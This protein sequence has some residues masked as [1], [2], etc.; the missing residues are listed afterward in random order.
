METIEKKK[1]HSWKFAFRSLHGLRRRMILSVLC[2]MVA[3]IINYLPPMV[4]RFTLDYVVGGKA[5]G[6]PVPFLR[7]LES[8]GGRNF[9]LGHIFLCG[10]AYFVCMAVSSA[11]FF[12]RRVFSTSAAEGM[13]KNMRDALYTQLHDVP[14]DYHKH[15]S[16]GDIVQR[17]IS[18][19]NTVRRFFSLQVMEM[20]RTVLMFFTAF[21]IMMTIDVPL[22][23]LSLVTL[24][25]L[26]AASY[27]YFRYVKKYFTA[28]DVAEGALST[29]I[30]ENLTGARVV[31]AFGQQRSQMD[32]FMERNHDYKQKTSKLLHMLGVYW[33]S[34]D[35]VGFVQIFLTLLFGV[36]FA[37]QGRLSVGDVTLF[38]AY[39]GMLTWP[40]RQFGRILADMGKSS[41]ALGRL[42][43]I[44]DAKREEE[45]GAALLPPMRGDIVF[46]DV[47][48]G[49]DSPDEVLK[50]LSFTVCAGQ[51]VG[52]LGSTGSGKSSL[53]QL[54][55]RLYQ[56]SGGQITV[57]GTD[58]REIAA[59]HLRRN[60]SLVAQ[61][62]FLYSRS[63]LENIR[64]ARPG[65]T[66]EEVFAAASAAAIHEDITEFKEGYSTVVGERGVTL[67]GGQRQRVAIARALLQNAPVMIFD[68]SM[69][70][71]D[72][73]TD[74]RI[75]EALLRAGENKTVFLISH[76]ITTLYRAHMIL[77]LED[78]RITAQG[79]H[80]EL[81]QREGLYKRIAEIQDFTAPETE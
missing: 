32:L 18:D 70:A 60:I 56:A 43:E 41:V 46:R 39:T 73:E 29:T 8:L 66:D 20:V 30:Q 9:I 49:Y 61:E 63:I 44:M 50:G 57:N 64:M 38:I 21:I 72:T 47:C 48:F 34:S 11:F 80:T 74:R 68:D 22:T 62:P 58:I 14:Y 55:L 4:I 53:V 75:R 69:S 28:S 40:M 36:L 77:V 42:D 13:A 59:P 1:K 79:T 25:V 52:I 31:R 27:L 54:L 24:P 71:V 3:V 65:A 45:P 6:F 35:T 17:C 10:I 26:S 19:V 51:T 12:L 7:L 76:R 16:A 23:L 33:G 81:M 67:S 2:M 37:V 78:G 15:V 5:D